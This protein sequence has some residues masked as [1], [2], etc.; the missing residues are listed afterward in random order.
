M[1]LDSIRSRGKKFASSPKCPFSYLVGIKQLVHEV[2]HSP[3]W[4]SWFISV[5]PHHVWCSFLRHC[6]TSLKVMGLIT[7]GATGIFHWHN[8]S[9]R[10][11][12]LES[13]QPLTEM[14]TRNISLAVKAAGVYG[15]QRY[16][17]HVPIVLKTG[18]LNLLEP[19]G[20]V[21]ACKGIAL[22]L[23]P[24]SQGMGRDTVTLY[25]AYIKLN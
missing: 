4:V 5:L 24:P 15:W 3:S 22:L 17:F 2:S 12:A 1:I 6:A 11:M 14:C 18:N 10:T 19:G 20:S 21:E 9:S 16:H 25:M 23:P 7:D 8:P 13:T